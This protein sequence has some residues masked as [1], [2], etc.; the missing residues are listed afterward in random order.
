[1]EKIWFKENK[2]VTKRFLFDSRAIA[3]LRAKAKSERIPKPLRNKAL[4][5]FIWKHATATSSIASGS[6][7]LL[8]ATHAVNLRPRMKPNNSLD[9][10]TRNL[11]WWAFAAT[12]PTNEGVR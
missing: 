1:M 7:K 2:Y 10:S 3:A 12:N 4:T 11:F 6:P 5:G 9:T 8:I